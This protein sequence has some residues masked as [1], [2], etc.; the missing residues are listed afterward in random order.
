MIQYFSF[1]TP[2]PENAPRQRG[3]VLVLILVAVALFGALSFTVA[4]MM[5][6]GSGERISEQ[7][8]GLLADEILAYGR[9]LRQGVQGLKISNGCDEAQISFEGTGLSG[10]GHTPAA[11]TRCTLFHESGADLAYFKPSAE[12]GNVTDWIFTG[13]LNVQGVGTDCASGDS[14]TELLAVLSG[15]NLQVCKAINKKLGVTTPDDAPPVQ[16][17]VVGFSKF[18]GILTYAATVADQAGNGALEGQPA[19]CSKASDS[20]TYFFYQSLM[21]R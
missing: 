8:A 7:K 17:G 2:V 6:S 13:Q 19:G 3:S 21:N 11:T 15:I 14:C 4:N 5:R 10:Y 1:I 9:Q 16:D 12:F 20:D 18:T